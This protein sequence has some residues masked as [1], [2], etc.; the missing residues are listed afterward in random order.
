[1]WRDADCFVRES[2]FDRAS[3]NAGQHVDEKFEPSQSLSNII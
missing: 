3:E 1:M 2:Y